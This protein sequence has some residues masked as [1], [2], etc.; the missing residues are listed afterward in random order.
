MNELVFFLKA[1]VF[2]AASVAL[3]FGIALIIFY[4][5]FR[6][7]N[8]MI[9]TGYFDKK[10]KYQ[11]SSGGYF[12][13]NLVIGWHTGIGIVSLLIAAWLFFMFSRY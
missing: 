7:F 11:V 8:E 12:M 6:L 10:R 4:D 5:R 2:I 9:N 1:M 3:V 13:D